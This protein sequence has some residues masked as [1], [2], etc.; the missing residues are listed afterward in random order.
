MRWCVLEVLYTLLLPSDTCPRCFSKISPLDSY[1]LIPSEY[2]K[3]LGYRIHRK[4]FEEL[5]ARACE[6]VKQGFR[7]IWLLERLYNKYMPPSIIYEAISQA[8][9][10]L[11]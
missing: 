3:R 11:S 8:H 6:Y 1:L 9:T 7:G 5:K 10:C 4:C 2:G